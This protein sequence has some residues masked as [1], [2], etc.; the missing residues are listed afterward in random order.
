[1]NNLRD[2]LIQSQDK[3][4]GAS[5]RGVALATVTNT[6]E[7]SNGKVKIKF[8]W[9]KYKDENNQDQNDEIDARIITPDKG[10]IPSVA[11][12]DVVLVAFEQGNFEYPFIIGFIYPPLKDTE[13]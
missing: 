13:S 9:R 1:M 11:V 5:I 7:L 4:N 12:H 2:Y 3:T 10:S 8:Q 6:S